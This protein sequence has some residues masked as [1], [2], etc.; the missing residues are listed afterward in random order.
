MA[1]LCVATDLNGVSFAGIV[2]EVLS[3]ELDVCQVV[4]VRTNTGLKMAG[5]APEADKTLP[6]SFFSESTQ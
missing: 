3:C 4:Q 5:I 6:D 1:E 2:R